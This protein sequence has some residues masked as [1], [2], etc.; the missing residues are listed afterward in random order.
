MLHMLQMFIGT[1]ILLALL[2]ICCIIYLSVNFTIYLIQEKFIFHADKLPKNHKFCIKGDFEEINLKTK[3]G[4]ILNGILFEQVNAKGIVF[5]FHNHAGNISNSF[6]FVEVFKNLNYSALLMDY[7][8]YGKSTGKFNEQLMLSD[9]KLW[10]DFVKNIYDQ[11]RIVIIGRGLGAT[12]AT[13]IAAKNTP[14]HLFLGSPFYN[15]NTVSKKQY[16]YLLIGL[17]L[18]YKFDTAKYLKNVKCKTYIFHGEKDNLVHYTNSVKLSEISKEN[19]EL[20]LIP[21]GSHYNLRTNGPAIQRIKE[22][23]H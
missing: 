2:F 23:L 15:L 13:Y 17:I 1:N 11:D 16:P 4:N 22:V 20:N 21:D 5:Y 9:A 3:D 8:G 14:K 12:F 6:S 18:K 7:R 10:Y 19:I